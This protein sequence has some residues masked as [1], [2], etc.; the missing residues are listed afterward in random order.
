[1]CEATKKTFPIE[2]CIKTENGHWVNRVLYEY[3]KEFYEQESLGT[4]KNPITVEDI[5]HFTFLMNKYR[6]K[7]SKFLLAV[8][9]SSVDMEQGTADAIKWV[10]CREND[11]S[12]THFGEYLLNENIYQNMQFLDYIIT[13]DRFQNL[14]HIHEPKDPLILLQLEKMYLN[15]RGFANQ[16]I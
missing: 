10:L 2:L 11:Y 15:K 16:V 6:K 1:M 7:L 12:I 8:Y 4:Y 3:T 14:Q 9:K 13:S 5:Q